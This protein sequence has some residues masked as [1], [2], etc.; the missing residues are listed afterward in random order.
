MCFL[1]D[2]MI[3]LKSSATRV[4]FV[5]A[6]VLW[7]ELMNMD[8]HRHRADFWVWTYI[9]YKADCGVRTHIEY[10]T[11]V[12]LWQRNAHRVRDWVLWRE[13][14][15][16]SSTTRVNFI[17]NGILLR[18][19]MTRSAARTHDYGHTEFR[20]DSRDVFFKN[21]SQTTAWLAAFSWL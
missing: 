6:R 20:S 12:R 15:N 2:L 13:L 5:T 21:A 9:A 17:T 10:R 4:E 8:T 19:L 1:R 3:F 7:R 11:D 14:C 18:E 16:M